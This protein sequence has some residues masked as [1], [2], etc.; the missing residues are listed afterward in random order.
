LAVCRSSL[1]AGG[2]FARIF[3]FTLA[4]MP[5][6]LPRIPPP[7]RDTFPPKDPSQLFSQRAWS[8]TGRDFFPFAALFFFLPL[9]GFHPSCRITGF[10][11]EEAEPLSVRSVPGPLAISVFRGH[12]FP[13]LRDVPWVYVDLFEFSLF[14]PKFLWDLVGPVGI[15]GSFREALVI[16]SPS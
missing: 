4:L 1:L 6:L 11:K 16:P 5:R 13:S 15:R 2:S 12:S 10:L 9:Y 8:M 7:L 14:H 3:F